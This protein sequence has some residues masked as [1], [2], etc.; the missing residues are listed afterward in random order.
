MNQI[1]IVS[2]LT[3]HSRVRFSNS[4]SDS[5]WLDPPYINILLAF[6]LRLWVYNEQ[7][8]MEQLTLRVQNSQLHYLEVCFSDTRLYFS[9]C[10]LFPDYPGAVLLSSLIGQR[11]GPDM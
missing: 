2:S 1:N 3:E 8:K 7:S 10:P 4:N 11:K 9:P 6:Q 5:L